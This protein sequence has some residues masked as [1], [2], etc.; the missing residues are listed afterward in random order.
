MMSDVPLGCFLSGGL[1]SSI[2]AALAI[3][4]NPKLKTFS[5]G[6]DHNYFSECNYVDEVA[7]F[8]GSNHF[9]Y[10][11]TQEDFKKNFSS[12]LHAIDEPYA[13]SSAFAVYLLSKYVKEDVTVALSGDGADEVFGG[14]RKH[15]ADFKIRKMKGS[16]KALLKLTA[17]G[18]KSFRSNRSDRWGELNRKVQKLNK[19]LLLDH[20][21]R[22]IKWCQFIEEDG[23][24]KL[25]L[26]NFESIAPSFNDFDWEDLISMANSLE[27]RTPFLDTKVVDFANS[28]PAS[29][30][31][32]ENG[33]KRI[34]KDAFK[35]ILPTSVL[36]RSK[37]G[38][39]IP[40]K[41]RLNDEIDKILNGPL[42]TNG[43]LKNQDLF[44]P[45][46]INNLRLEW[47][48]P[49]FGDKTYMVWA[50]IVF[51]YWW[52]RNHASA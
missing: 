7:Q 29:Y 52:N 43:Y 51:Q 23:R 17:A 10:I 24:E 22:Y 6:F 4:N 5:I 46:Y 19:G 45:E 1:D 14:Y 20:Q 49:N 48:Q 41:Q 21:S 39:E 32:D 40:I 12:F 2:I 15:F 33:G 28:L 34:L 31:I 35:E 11:L 16:K 9:K 18:L 26:H 38:F 50:L 8:I 36:N 47:N 13:D 42:F 27:F 3:K 25:L 44:K 30:K 37:K